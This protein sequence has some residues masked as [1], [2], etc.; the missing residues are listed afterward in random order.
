[1]GLYSN[2]IR[3]TCTSLQ[4]YTCSLRVC[5]GNP[6]CKGEKES[7][8]PAGKCCDRTPIKDVVR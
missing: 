7:I 6:T 2:L 1:M 5:R 4:G 3:S 8:L